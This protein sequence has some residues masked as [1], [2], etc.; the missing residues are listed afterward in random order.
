MDVSLS[1]LVCE[2]GTG[3]ENGGYVPAP[4]IRR[5]MAHFMSNFGRTLSRIFC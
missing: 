2:N 4:E 5:P 1:R 3:G